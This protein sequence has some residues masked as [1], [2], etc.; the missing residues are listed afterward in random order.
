M[1]SISHPC[2]S[3]CVCVCVCLCVAIA[4]PGLCFDIREPR[5]T[6]FGGQ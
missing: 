1:Y 6:L 4:W 2:A 3:V 5:M